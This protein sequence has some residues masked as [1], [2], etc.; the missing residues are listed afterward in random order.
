MIAGVRWCR[1]AGR[2]RTGAVGLA[3][4]AVLLGTVGATGLAFD[5]LV[6]AGFA[7]AALFAVLAPLCCALPTAFLAL[8][9]C[10]RNP[11]RLFV[12]GRLAGFRAVG[13]CDGGRR[14]GRSGSFTALFGLGLRGGIWPVVRVDRH[15]QVELVLE[16]VPSH[17]LVRG[18][19]PQRRRRIRADGD[20]PA[21]TGMS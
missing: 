3:R 15:V 12:F 5:G 6:G 4:S 21:P 1:L 2:L 7:D 8:G 14:L 18:N 13:L 20:I 17:P 19:L 16:G 11:L 10:E 9:R